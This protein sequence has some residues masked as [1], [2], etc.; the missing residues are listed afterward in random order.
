MSRMMEVEANI[1]AAFAER[2]GSL[3]KNEIEPRLLATLT[4]STMNIAVM[5]WYLGDFPD[6]T[7]AVEQVFSQLTRIVCAQTGSTQRTRRVVR[8]T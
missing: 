3:S 7:A 6:L 2:I 8:R 4:L 5:S 1:A